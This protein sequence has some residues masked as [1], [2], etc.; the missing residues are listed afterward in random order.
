M[1]S[2]ENKIFNHD[3]DYTI[4]VEEEYMLCDPLNGELI[5]RAKDIFDNVDNEFKKRLSYELK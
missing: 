2:Y 3:I 1:I 5:N 4:G